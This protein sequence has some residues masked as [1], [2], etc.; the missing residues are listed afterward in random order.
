MTT[1]TKPKVL[2][3]F[4]KQPEER[5]FFKVHCSDWLTDQND[6]IASYVIAP[7]TGIT[8]SNET[9]LDGTIRALYIGGVDGESYK[10]TITLT[11][12]S[13]QIKEL[14]FYIVVLEV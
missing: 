2:G 11:L 12:T 1:V 8:Y 9:L 14:E 3:K 6:T 13:G 10:V 4:Y 5:R 7:E